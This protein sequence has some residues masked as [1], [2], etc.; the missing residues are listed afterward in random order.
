MNSFHTPTSRNSKPSKNNSCISI[1]NTNKKI[2]NDF[3]I[4]NELRRNSKQQQYSSFLDKI[5]ELKTERVRSNKKLKHS[6]ST[7]KDKNKNK[8]KVNFIYQTKKDKYKMPNFQK[9]Q[10]NIRQAIINMNLEIKKKNKEL[11]HSLIQ[12]SDNNLSL[13]SKMPRHAASIKIK[14][15]TE[16]KSIYKNDLASNNTLNNDTH[17]LEKIKNEKKSNKIFD[18]VVIIPINVKKKKQNIKNNPEEKFRNLISKQN[19]F[20]SIDDD[21]SEEEIEPDGIYISPDNIIILILDYVVLICSLYTMIFIPVD[22]FKINSFYMFCK[23]KSYYFRYF[24]DVIYI[25]DFLISF[26]RGYYDYNCQI[27]KSNKKM[28]F[29]Y[30]KNDCLFDLIE[31]IPINYLSE[32]WCH[33]KSQTLTYMI[34]NKI[35]IYK[36]LMIL[37]S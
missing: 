30:L 21:E 27:I 16:I 35:V 26:F 37:K 22:I 17:D 20:D 14:K 28:F 19:V 31:A 1:N 10:E 32:K 36:M 6:S 2:A 4:I 18:S 9:I 25:F 7:N 34:D 11:D 24:V 5:T 15:S 8:K 33:N 29:D 3:N 12:T 23:S 13:I